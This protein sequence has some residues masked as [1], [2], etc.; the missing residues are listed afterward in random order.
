MSMPIDLPASTNRTWAE[1]ITEAWQSTL[2]GILETG[3]LLIAAKEGPDRLPHGEFEQMV[4]TDLP[5]GASTAQRLMAVARDHR[6]S[7][8]A[9]VQLLP[10]HWG[11]LYEITKLPDRD[12]FTR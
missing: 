6:L 9:H 10:P 8:A 2:H 1:R 11:T 7:K 5:F 4:A 3:R 12:A